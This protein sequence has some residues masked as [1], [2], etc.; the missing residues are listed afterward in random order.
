MADICGVREGGPGG[1]QLA[2]LE[3]LA[4]L[5]V[6]YP[7]YRHAVLRTFEHLANTLDITAPPQKIQSLYDKTMRQ[8]LV[9]E[10][11]RLASRLKEYDR[12][13]PDKDLRALD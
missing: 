4:D 2:S 9:S 10:A 11:K 6:R 1:G 3:L 13:H 5:G 12:T 7:L 8:A